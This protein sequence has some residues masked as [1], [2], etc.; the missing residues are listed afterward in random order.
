MYSDTLNGVN[1][2]EI[3]MSGNDPAIVLEV[4]TTQRVLM[5]NQQYLIKEPLFTSISIFAKALISKRA[6]LF[7]Q[8]RCS[9]STRENQ[10]GLPN[11]FSFTRSTSEEEKDTVMA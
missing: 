8:D 7:L 1:I 5:K 3:K 10:L 11:V 6:A 9:F 2:R 4:S